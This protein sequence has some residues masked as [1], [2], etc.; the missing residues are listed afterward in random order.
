MDQLI[1][2][3]FVKINENV[4]QKKEKRIR[5]YIYMNKEDENRIK[6]MNMFLKVFKKMI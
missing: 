1:S 6:V 3:L 5:S 2:E 4:Q